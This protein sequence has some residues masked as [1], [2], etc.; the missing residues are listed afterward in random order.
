MNNDEKR[1]QREAVG[2]RLLEIAHKAQEAV[3][4]YLQAVGIQEEDLTKINLGIY[5]RQGGT[6]AT[7]V[8]AYRYDPATE[9]VRYIFS[10]YE[11]DDIKSHNL[12][13]FMIPFL[14]EEEQDDG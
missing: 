12:H 2:E 1:V 11:C 10:A 14:G 4:E 5:H 9:D 6:W 13:R 3:L 8:E 7:E